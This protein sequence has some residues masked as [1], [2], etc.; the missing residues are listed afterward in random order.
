MV[1]LRIGDIRTFTSQLFVREG[2]DG[3]FLRE[4]QIVTYNS[5]TIDGRIRPGYYTK[6]EREI[7]HIGEYSSWKTVRPVCYSLI[8]GKK[9]PESFRLE[10][11]LGPEDTEKVLKRAGGSWNPEAVKGLYLGVRYENGALFCVTGLSLGV[12][13]MDKTLEYQWDE[14]VK[15]FLKANDIIFSEE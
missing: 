8:R 7:G 2:F 12:F 9:L 11:A 13:T 15:A 3:F 10:F 1:A 4:A 6:D 14:T 5:F